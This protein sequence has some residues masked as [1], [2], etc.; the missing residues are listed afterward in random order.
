MGDDV[1]FSGYPLNQNFYLPTGLLLAKKARR[2]HPGV[3]KHQQVAGLKQL[4]E[5]T[6]YSVVKL[7]RE[8]VVTKQPGRAAI[9]E[10]IAGDQFVRQVKMKIGDIHGMDC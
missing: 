9:L 3:V 7:A 5:F 2:D 4:R 10:W 8:A 1:M 6:E